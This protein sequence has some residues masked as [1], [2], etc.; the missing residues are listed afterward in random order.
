[1]GVDTDA[2]I[3]GGTVNLPPVIKEWADNLQIT[4]TRYSTEWYEARNLD[5]QRF[6][7]SLTEKQAEEWQV[8]Q[9][10]L[11]NT[12]LRKGLSTVISAIERGEL[13]DSLPKLLPSE[14]ALVGEIPPKDISSQLMRAIRDGNVDALFVAALLTA[15]A[16]SEVAQ[17]AIDS[18]RE[19]VDRHNSG[20]KK[21]SVGE[22]VDSRTENARTSSVAFE[23]Q[24]LAS[25]VA[26]ALS[27]KFGLSPAHQ[28]PSWQAV[29]SS[30]KRVVPVASAV[31]AK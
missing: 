29:L 2:E 21:V 24:D 13:P 20:E 9:D 14:K 26:R 12:A 3:E 4:P 22:Y 7:G 27:R 25:G 17:R 31:P 19:M 28:Y 16:G 11:D 8:F 30:P 18:T 15:Q 23:K 5:I 1:M 6:R 10:R